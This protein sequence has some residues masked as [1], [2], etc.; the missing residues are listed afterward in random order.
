MESSPFEHLLDSLVELDLAIQMAKTAA[1]RHVPPQPDML[2]RFDSYEHILKKQRIL[3]NGLRTHATR[4]DWVEVCRDIKIISGLSAM[5]R[6]DAWEMIDG[7]A[8]QVKPEE[9]GFSKTV[10]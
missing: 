2:S 5:I 9:S 7:S 4:R 6:D 10:Q 1:V 3:A 8:L